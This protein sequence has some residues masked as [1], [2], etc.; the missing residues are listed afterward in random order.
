[1]TNTPAPDAYPLQWP[2]GWK[3]TQYRKPSHYKVTESK[4]RNDLIKAVKCLGGRAIIIS[5]NLPVKRD[6]LPYANVGV[7]ADPGVAVYWTRNNKQEV[8]A[9][10]RWKK[11]WENM[12]AISQAVLAMRTIER[13][14]ATQIL[15]RMFHAFA[16]PENAS[17]DAVPWRDVLGAHINTREEAKA[18]YRDKVSQHHPDLGGDVVVFDRI[19]KA[20]K[21]ALE[22]LTK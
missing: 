1:M 5:S 20:Y 4:A 10:D 13:T 9:C 22:E 19:N 17:E 11:P 16:L 14:G 6:G 8:M 18:S 3:R 12:R 7:P 2:A 15:E 21:N